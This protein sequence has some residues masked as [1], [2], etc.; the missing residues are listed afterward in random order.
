MTTLAVM[1]SAFGRRL[2]HRFVVPVA[3]ASTLVVGACAVGPDTGP[4]VVT[5]GGGGGNAPA[6]SSTSAQ[7]P[8]LSAPK[9]DLTW[10]DCGTT[11]ADRY[12]LAAPSDVSI[13]CATLDSPV[14]PDRPDGDTLSV[15]VT[16]ARVSDT[17]RDAAPLVLTSGTDL[18]SSRTL[19]LLAAGPGRSLLQQHPVVAIDRRGIPES[20]PLDCL[21]RAER[22]SIASNGLTSTP[23][24]SAARINRLAQSA[25]SGADGCTETLSPNQLA[26]GVPE[27][28]FDIETLRQKWNVDRL[29]LLG[30]GEG[31]DVVL[32]YAANFGGRAGRI[33]LDTPTPFGANAR[34]RAGTAANGVQAALTTFAQRCS[35][36]PNCA[37]GSNGIATIN[38]V[39]DK[40]R[41]GDLPGLTDTQALSAITTAVATTTDA[42]N[43]L[44]P[45]ASAIA[46]ADRGDTTALRRLATTAA[47]LRTT[48]G[49]LVAR[50]ND[51]TGPVGQNEIPGL[52]DAWT[53]Q[54]PTTGADAA[55]TLMR[56]NGWSAGTA[57][58]PPTSFPANP[59]V[60]NG[61][62]DT[63]N[64]GAGAAGLTPLFVRAGADPTTVTWDGL[65]YSVVAHTTCAADVVGQYLQNAPLSGPS[66]RGCPA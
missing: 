20:S 3:L 46:A 34:D 9:A 17:P 33:V 50:C 24:D 39:L 38:R 25:S 57:V 41:T 1:R 52:I 14:N 21:T 64:G 13:E 56:C 53:K 60:L 29:A 49:Q 18:P 32:T 66:Q 40:G 65:G 19:M 8:A 7:L 23:L 4:D 42:P 5:G 47:D 15:S 63:I 10:R 62:G 55:L 28:A 54:Y 35:T 26:F 59:L 36:L 44:T 27:A 12:Q 6:E 61:S 43:G 58:N 37:L 22:I 2:A 45:I 16:R 48:D 11:T 30:V 51:T 31:S